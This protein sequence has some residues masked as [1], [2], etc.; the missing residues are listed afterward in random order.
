MHKLIIASFVAAL[1]GIT[2]TPSTAKAGNEVAAAIGGFIGGVI[3][4]TAV[5]DRDHCPPPRFDQDR[6][7]R[8]GGRVIIETGPRGHGHW[9]WIEVRT[10]VPG[11]H[12]F[13][14]DRCGRRFR[15]WIPGHQ[16]IRR[17]RL[18]V[19]SDR[20]RGLR[21]EGYAYDRR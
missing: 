19:D 14:Y 4:G 20:R 18:W 17:E 6:Y 13:S 10:W 15:T 16:E 5:N 1:G 9:K 2:A 3:V 11:Y 21:H 7:P 12:S 8:R